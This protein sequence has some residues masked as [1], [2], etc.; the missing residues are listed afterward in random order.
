MTKKDNKDYRMVIMKDK[1]NDFQLVD[2]GFIVAEK[3]TATIFS[4][5]KDGTETITTN[6]IDYSKT[7]VKT[8]VKTLEKNHITTVDTKIESLQTTE[9]PKSIEYVVVL[10]DKQGHPTKQITI[11]EDKETKET[12]VID[13]TTLESQVK[14]IKPVEPTVTVI[15]ETEYY[16]PEIKELISKV[17]TKSKDV[18]IEKVKKIEVVETSEAKKY[19]FIVEETKG[20]T[21]KIEAVQIK[22]ETSVE[23]VKVKPY[24]LTPSEQTVK[25]VKTVKMVN[26]QGIKVEY[27]NDRKVLSETSTVKTA[28]AEIVNIKPELK[29]FEVVSS[30]TKDYVHH[31]EQVLIMT[32]GEK[33]VQVVG[34]VDQKTLRYELIGQKEVPLEVTIPVV[35]QNTIPVSVYPTIV[36]RNKGLKRCETVVTDK[37]KIFKNKLPISTTVE[38]FD[39]NEIISFNFQVGPK[40]FVAVVQNDKVNK[41]CKI[42]EVNPIVVTKPIKTDQVVVEGKTITTSTS[43]EEIKKVNKVTETVLTEV[44]HEYPELTSEE[45]S[46]VTLIESDFS[47]VYEVTYKNE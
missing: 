15:S 30:Q 38:H 32:N 44:V 45:I 47:N 21:V 19:E 28:V 37:F 8:V 3:A 41:N 46:E 6:K 1:K 4:E 23:V 9:G 5:N 20:K 16:K 35:S 25:E 7:E 31:Q 29:T 17:E 43:V 13:Y 42:I 18:V 27:T 11:T 12:T 36:K 40:R 33:T 22:G 14:Y 26:E 39:E 10:S 24:V 34:H 2:E